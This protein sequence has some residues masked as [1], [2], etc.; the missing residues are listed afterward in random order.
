MTSS[1]AITARDLDPANDT[2]ELIGRRTISGKDGSG[3]GAFDP[4][5]GIFLKT[6][7]GN[8]LGF[9]D[10][11]KPGDWSQ[12]REIEVVP[13]L[14]SGSPL[15]FIYHG[16]QY[17]PTLQAFLLWDGDHQVWLLDPPDDLDPD[18]DGVKSLS[19]RLDTTSAEPHWH[20]P[21]AARVNSPVSSASGST[22]PPSAPTLVSSIQNPGTSLSTSQVTAAFPLQRILRTSR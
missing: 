7:T 15:E 17:D 12:N 14:Q 4:V 10:V 21:D 18:G 22:C 2:W 6:L 20:R 13:T 19:H 5:Q 1:G 9:W 3:A 11:N 8:S 16:L